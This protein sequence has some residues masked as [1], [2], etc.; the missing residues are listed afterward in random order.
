[1]MIISGST[2]W[3]GTKELDLLYTVHNITLV[4]VSKVL[5]KTLKTSSFV[6]EKTQCVSFLGD[7]YLIR[8]SK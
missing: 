8:K 1:M 2:K 4:Y 5:C 6:E 7:K 3:E